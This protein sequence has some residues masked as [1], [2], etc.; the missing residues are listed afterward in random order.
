M[1]AFRNNA[2]LLRLKL[3]GHRRKLP[4]FLKKKIFDAKTIDAEEYAAPR[5]RDRERYAGKEARADKRRDRNRRHVREHEV[6][7]DTERRGEDEERRPQDEQGSDRS[8]RACGGHPKRR[9]E[10]F[11]EQ[12][13]KRRHVRMV[14]R[15]DAKHGDPIGE[16]KG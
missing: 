15:L 12:F 9:R 2:I 14:A 13:Q 8:Q 7:C 4:L 11:A 1:K 10:T 5:V 16:R 3:V 6:L